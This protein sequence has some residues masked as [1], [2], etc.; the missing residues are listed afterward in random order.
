MR[1]NLSV[2]VVE[3]VKESGNFTG[4]HGEVWTEGEQ[5]NVLGSFFYGCAHVFRSVVAPQ[6]STRH[7]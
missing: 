3:M 7:V 6:L 5:G 2:A 4:R 1:V